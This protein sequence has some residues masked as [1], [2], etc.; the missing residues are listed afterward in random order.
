MNSS[1]S[2]GQVPA[3]WNEWKKTYQNT[4][5]HS[6]FEWDFAIDVIPEVIG[7]KP[8]QVIPQYPFIG[9]DGRE[10]H[11]DFAIISDHAKIAIE[12]EGYDKTG[13]GTGKSKKEHDEFNRR[14]QHLTRLGWK[15]LPITNAQFMKDKMGY[16][17]EIRQLMAKSQPDPVVPAAITS[18]PIQKVSSKFVVSAVSIAL[19]LAI[20][21]V[22][23][24]GRDSTDSD[25]VGIIPSQFD[26]GQ[27]F[28]NC[29]EL[30]AVFA[31]G[32]ARDQASRD[33]KDYSNPVINESVYLANP[34]LDGNNDGVMCD[35]KQVLKN[36]SSWEDHEQMIDDQYLME[37]IEEDQKL[38]EDDEEEDEEE[39]SSL[40]S[41]EY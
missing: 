27:K 33:K 12:L 23:V 18:S 10:Y 14:I 28:R 17:N 34:K 32:V 37:S 3:D 30:N 38:A 31:G 13:N 26:S 6:R 1:N 39:Q 8:S 40:S 41:D 2:K 19:A 21:I 7:L 22:F 20:A 36:M 4:I 16:A 25:R 9:R 35:S 11:M 24:F 5:R 15:V 29:E